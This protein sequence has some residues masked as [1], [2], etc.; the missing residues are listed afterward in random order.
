MMTP[1][2]NFISI[3]KKQD[4]INWIDTAGEGVPSRASAPFRSLRWN[5]DSATARR[6]WCQREEILAAQ[7]TQQRVAGGGR[8]PALGALEDLLLEKLCCATSR[9]KRLPERG[10]QL[11]LYSST[12]RSLKAT[13][14]FFETPPTGLLSSRSATICHCAGEP[15]VQP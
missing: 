5:F 3:W 10:M 15:T 1:K 9:K 2:C 4:V 12:A 6:W 8:K 11:K 14:A 7:P 13:S